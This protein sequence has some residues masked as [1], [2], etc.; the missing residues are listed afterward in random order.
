MARFAQNDTALTREVSLK[1]LR[2]ATQHYAGTA[3]PEERGAIAARFDLPG[4]EALSWEIDSTPWRSG[5]RLSGRV[6]ARVVQECI[7]TLDPVPAEIDET[8]ERG[9]LPFDDLYSEDSPGSEHEIVADADL[10]DIP[11]SLTD[12]LDIGDVV[13]E[14]LGVALDPYPRKAGLDEDLR[15]TAQPEGIAP[16]TE[17]DVKPFAGLADL[18]KQMKM[19]K[20]DD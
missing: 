11:E 1:D 17:A 12:P 5:V 8:F 14:E 7:V 6:R 9:F 4:V 13:A 10:G 3:S 2:G 19:P 15:Y 18:A 20:S 16:L